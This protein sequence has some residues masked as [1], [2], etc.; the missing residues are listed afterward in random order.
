MLADGRGLGV[1]TTDRGALDLYDLGVRGLLAWDA[2]ALER[3]RA[4]AARDE[5][6]A[7]A[8]AGAAVC[9]FLDERFQEARAEAAAARMA[10][11]AQSARERGHVEA[12]ALLTGGKTAEAEAAMRAHLAAYP[13]DLVILQR[14]YFILF[15]QGRFAEMLAL[16]GDLAAANSDD[17]FM[18]GLHAFALEEGGRRA[19]A[20]RAAEAALARDARDAWAVH[21]FAH[22]L[23][24]TGR[25]EEG[26]AALPARI[27]PC[28]QLGWFRDHLLWHL[29]LMHLACGGYDRARALAR[30]VFE[31]A[32]SPIAGDLHDSISLLWRFEL[33]GRPQGGAWA[34]FAAIARERVRRPGLLYHA[35]HLAMA[36]AM[37][38]DWATAGEQLGLLRERAAKDRSDLV[39]GVALPLIEG[40][41]AF[42]GGDYAR[43]IER[44][45]SLSPRIVE[46]GGSRAQRDVFHDTLLEAC[47]RA[48]DLERGTRLLAA[49]LQMRAEHF[50]LHRARRTP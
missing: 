32:P 21:A 43:V 16:T 41:H 13:R 27:E 33:Y 36:L 24:E 4:A 39:A 37:A 20:V 17:S 15:W 34:P 11:E 25:S 23:Y 44:I 49:R 31:R 35:A 12:I 8:R 29:A 22:A 28:V 48:G 40:L 50:W 7:L 14:L 42:A 30:E 6:L 2:G 45:E 5:R 3:F 18:L 47:F 10:A 38:G 19:E 1:T 26:L 9:L 46:L